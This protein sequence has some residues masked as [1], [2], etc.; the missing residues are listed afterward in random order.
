MPGGRPFYKP[1]DDDRV[2]VRNMAAAGLSQQ[3]IQLCLPAAPKHPKTFCKAFKAELETSAFEVTARA[4]SKLVGAINNG[5][6]WAICFWLKSKAG[7]EERQ[8]HRLVDT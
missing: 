3:T 5:E 7:F 2:L 8:A 6:A 4:M 1:T